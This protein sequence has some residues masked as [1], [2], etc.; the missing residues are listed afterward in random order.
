[1]RRWKAGLLVVVVLGLL[2]VLLVWSPW[3][4]ISLA[5]ATVVW[6]VASHSIAPPPGKGDVMAVIVSGDGG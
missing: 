2:A 3:S 4:R 5:K 6:P 1:M